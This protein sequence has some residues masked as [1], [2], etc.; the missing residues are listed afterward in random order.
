MRVL[1]ADKL[2]ARDHADSTRATSPL[3]PADDAV[4]ID[5]GDLS[6]DEVVARVLALTS[7]I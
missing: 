6:I 1:I 2:A 7:Q 3:K 5:T 4:V